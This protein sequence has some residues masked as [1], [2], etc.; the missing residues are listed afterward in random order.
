MKGDRSA[1]TLSAVQTGSKLARTLLPLII[2]R[3]NL[4]RSQR[5]VIKGDLVQQAAKRGATLRGR[6]QI[7]RIIAYELPRTRKFAGALEKA[8][9]VDRDALA[10]AWLPPRGTKY[11]HERRSRF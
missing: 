5:A 4:F 7:Q 9:H 11:S 6:S 8:V 2:K 1:D 10:T 3:L